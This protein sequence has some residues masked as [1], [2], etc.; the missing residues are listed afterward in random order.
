MD[1]KLNHISKSIDKIAQLSADLK[2]GDK[3]LSALAQ[4]L[5]KLEDKMLFILEE[6]DRIKAQR[7]AS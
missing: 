5:Q 6:D 7:K 2:K 4:R 1:K 3:G